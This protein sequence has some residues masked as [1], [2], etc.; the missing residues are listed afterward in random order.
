MSHNC[1]VEPIQ[2][3]ATADELDNVEVVYLAV[4]GMGCTNCAARVANSLLSVHGVT[5]A[6]VDH[7]IGVAKITY[8][9]NFAP[10]D[11]ILQAVSKAGGDGRHSYQAMKLA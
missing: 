4:R 10:I 8:N 6:Q 3:I 1:H 2:K 5:A 7:V 11:S 9:P